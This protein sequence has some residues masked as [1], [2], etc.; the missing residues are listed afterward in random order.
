MKN[1]KITRHDALPV[2]LVKLLEE[3]QPKTVKI[4][5]VAIPNKKNAGKSPNCTFDK[6]H[7]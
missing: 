3:E 4:L 7:T 5:L 2:E 1:N 6:P